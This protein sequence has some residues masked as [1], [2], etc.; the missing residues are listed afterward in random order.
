MWIVV[1]ML[2][3]LNV[4]IQEAVASVPA[5]VLVDSTGSSGS[6][7][8]Q[9]SGVTGASFDTSGNVFVADYYNSRIQKFDSNLDFVTKVGNQGTGNLQF[10]WPSDVAVAGDDGVWVVDTYNHR[11]KK[12]SNNLASMLY[13]SQVGGSSGSANGSFNRPSAIAIDGDGF[14]YVADR[15]NNRVQK[16]QSNGTY[17]TKW[18]SYG[19]TDGLFDNTTYGIAVDAG[20]N[21]WTLDSNSR[22]LQKF[23]NTGT[24][25]Q[26]ITLPSGS[27]TGS[28]SSPKQLDI[29]G[30]GNFYIADTSNNRVQILDS[31]GN[32]VNSYSGLTT[33]NGVSLDSS[34]YIFT[35]DNSSKLS[36][37]DKNGSAYQITN[38]GASLDAI[39]AATGNNIELGT[40]YGVTSAFTLRLKHSSGLTISDVSTTL[41][42]DSDWSAVTGESDQTTGKAFVNNLTSAPGTAA[43][44]TL[45]VPVPS[46]RTSSEVRICPDATDL[47][48]VSLSCT[49]GVTRSAGGPFV[50]SFGTITVSQ[51]SNL[52]DNV[53]YWKI[54][55]MAGSGGEST[56]LSTFSGSGSG[57]PGDPYQITTCTELQDMQS[58]LNAT[59]QLMNTIDC[60]A[61]TGWNGGNGFVPVGAS[62]TAA[63]TGTLLG[64]SKVVDSLYIVALQSGVGLFGYTNGATISNLSLTNLDYEKANNAYGDMGG[65]VGNMN[66]GSITGSSTTGSITQTASGPVARNF[67]GAVGI[68]YGAASLT[69]VTSAVN[70]DLRVA[71][72]NSGGMVGQMQ[73]TASITNSHATGYVYHG[74]E[75]EYNGG[76]V[77]W[78]VGSST[79]AN[80]SATGAVEF[81][82]STGDVQNSS[83]YYNGGFV[84][85]M[86]FNNTYLGSTSITNSFSTGTVTGHIQNNNTNDIY[87]YYTGGFAGR[88]D[89]GASIDES[90]ATGNIT[91]TIEDSYPGYTNSYG[92]VWYV[93]GF[94]GGT[95]QVF[96]GSAPAIT[97][98]Y[99]TGSITTNQ[100]KYLQEI[101]GFV[102]VLANGSITDSYATGS[103]TVSPDW[104]YGETYFT[105][106][107]LGGFAGTVKG[108]VSNSY[109]QGNVTPGGGVYY[110]GGFVGGMSSTLAGTVSQSYSTGS[111]QGTDYVGGFIGRMQYVSGTGASITNAYARGNAYSYSPDSDA[112]VGGFAGE[113]P[114]S[115]PVT[116]TYSTGTATV[117]TSSTFVGGYAGWGN[118]LSIVDSYWDTESSGT[119]TGNG[120]TTGYTT[121][122]MKT[123]ANF[124]TWD[125][126]TIWK[127]ESAINDG[128][129]SFQW[130][131]TTP[132]PSPT[133]TPTPAGS[134]TETAAASETSGGGSDT[135]CYE[136]APPS[137]PNNF[138]LVRRSGKRVTLAF[139][140][141][142]ENTSS[143][144]IV[145][146]TSPGDERFNTTI[147]A[148]K[149]KGAIETVIGE[150]DSSQ[151]YY[152]KVRAMN[153]CQPGPWSPEITTAKTSTQGG[154]KPLPGPPPTPTPVIEP[155]PEPVVVNEVEQV[156]E[157]EEI[158]VQVVD[159]ESEPLPETEVDIVPAAQELVE[160]NQFTQLLG[161]MTDEE[162]LITVMLMPGE[163][164]VQAQV[165]GRTVT[166]NLTVERTDSHA[167]QSITVQLDTRTNWEKAGEFA[168]QVTQVAV[169]TGAAV[170]AVSAVTG[171]VKTTTTISRAVA[172]I[173][174]T[175]ARSVVNLPLDIFKGLLARF[176]QVLNSIAGT[177][178]GFVFKRKRKTGKIFDSTNSRGIEGAYVVFYS[179]SGNLKS[180]F[181]DK[182]GMYQVMPPPDE[183]LIR[184]EKNGYRFPSRLITVPQ[185]SE[186]EHIYL[187]GEK[188]VIAKEEEIVRNIAVPLDPKKKNSKWHIFWTKTKGRMSYLIAKWRLPLAV[189]VLLITGLA[190]YSAQSLFNYSVF[191]TLSAVYGLGILSRGRNLG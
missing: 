19:T 131:A 62:S 146:G 78:M 130:Q 171:T 36:K 52:G 81:G 88:A 135:G 45:Y 38:L 93:G 177:I 85:L 191:G 5:I 40:S 8:G 74:Y 124:G 139:D 44:H 165:E 174:A 134:S 138:T 121:T 17:V 42:A 152:F 16:F 147:E 118:S 76:F 7:D 115:S 190:A 65:I 47:S 101:G 140:P 13:T 153:G 31:A 167:G 155:T 142:N 54:V 11:I 18:G 136:L 182:E 20:G 109:A 28:V 70:L 68:M 55:G 50:E 91:L 60:S 23:S 25:M 69:N 116:N 34:G 26:T 1:V 99:A 102:G 15:N 126:S 163:Y 178:F 143:Y 156:V 12:M 110:V 53:T 97:N 181:S 29:D 103:V 27:A 82:R 89:S 9:F 172:P 66:G 14:L 21:I 104:G 41:S 161:Q 39:N 90:Y 180:S 30:D 43:T 87:L 58:E 95:G 151:D 162:G 96:A 71:Q 108:T 59:Y 64:N 179:I 114:G 141:V 154:S 175:S 57:T 160:E 92:Q 145:Y 158:Q 106:A 72:W 6:G 122:Q 51:V 83:S 117:L 173:Y 170:A 79:I 105:A 168:E 125:F 3:G 86:G 150:L 176:W 32:Y 133:P 187:K 56:G 188:I 149:K 186:Y 111:V 137:A 73:G 113:I 100:G 185:N 94:V 157:P 184:T 159:E 189:S 132:S 61:T 166:A 77:G 80:S 144:L 119:A 112:E 49:N 128:Y 63:F 127:I 67:G 169:K 22:R 84:G 37:L 107:Y 46:G 4:V 48:S 123:Q 10:T 33:I 2:V 35:T 75:A 183:Y 98:S 120:G 164:L 129:P 148:S 24:W